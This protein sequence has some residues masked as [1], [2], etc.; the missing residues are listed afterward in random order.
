MVNG[1]A[2][3]SDTTSQLSTHTSCRGPSRGLDLFTCWTRLP[4]GSAG[5]CWVPH[6]SEWGHHPPSNS[7]HK[8]LPLTHLQHRMS[9]Q[10]LWVLSHLHL[11]N[12][13]TPSTITPSSLRTRDLS[14]WGQVGWPAHR[15][16]MSMEQVLHGCWVSIPLSPEFLELFLLWAPSSPPGP[17]SQQMPSTI[18]GFLKHTPDFSHPCFKFFS[19]SAF[20]PR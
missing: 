10:V 17:L 11:S 12:L 5:L 3:E 19:G 4:G 9:H 13:P 8:L 6:H 7:N 1:V 15:P 20:H 18:M 16:G 2:K 14:P